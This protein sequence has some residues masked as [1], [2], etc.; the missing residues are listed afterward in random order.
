MAVTLLVLVSLVGLINV[1]LYAK[2][3]E[4]YP[5]AP[6]KV[7]TVAPNIAPSEPTAMFYEVFSGIRCAIR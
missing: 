1:A 7:G 4:L 6:A 5:D 2:F 3:V